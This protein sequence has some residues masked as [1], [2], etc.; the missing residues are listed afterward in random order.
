MNSTNHIF[1]HIEPAEIHR[2]MLCFHAVKKEYP[3]GSHICSYGENSP[4][5]GIILSGHVQILRNYTDGHQTIL[6]QLDAGD[7][8]GEPLA[9]LSE[10]PSA[11]DVISTGSTSISFIDYSCL[12]RRCSNACTF[13]SQLVSNALLLTSQKA[14]RLSERL[15]ILSQ[16]TIREKL[17]CYFYLLS[18]KTGKRTFTLP[19]S[20]T[21]LADYLSVDRSAMMRELKK[22]KEEHLLITHRHTV[23]LL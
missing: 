17:Q 16:R 14:I 2:M 15:E 23:T 9:C 21:N 6:E 3:A 19:F 11:I 8:F 12:I 4:L 22:M 5:I 7:I 20:F 18:E 1:N 10:S 13:H